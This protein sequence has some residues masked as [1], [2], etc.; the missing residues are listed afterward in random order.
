MAFPCSRETTEGA[1]KTAG[2]HAFLGDTVVASGVLGLENPAVSSGRPPHSAGQRRPA[3][4][5]LERPLSVVLTSDGL[6]T[7]SVLDVFRP[8]IL[9]GHFVGTNTIG[10]GTEGDR[11]FMANPLSRGSAATTLCI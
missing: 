4:A 2:R 7:S 1:A 6:T 3:A 9:Q 11:A 10:D 5:A 8:R